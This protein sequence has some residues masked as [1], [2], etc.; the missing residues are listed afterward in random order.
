ME[1]EGFVNRLITAKN[2]VYFAHIYANRWSEHI[3]LEDLHNSIS[4]TLDDVAEILIGRGDV[5]FKSEELKA[6]DGRVMEIGDYLEDGFI[7]ML[8]EYRDIATDNKMHC[9][10]AKIDGLLLCANKSIYKLKIHMHEKR[11]AKEEIFEDKDDDTT[12]SNVTDVDPR[13]Y[14]D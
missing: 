4:D 14:T 10:V 5:T 9:I 8:S 12:D 3:V 13:E 11:K 6:T 1:C 2:I 7:G